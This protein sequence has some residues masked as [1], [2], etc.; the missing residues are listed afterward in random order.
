M[1]RT[2]RPVTAKVVV[3]CTGCGVELTKLAS[4]LKRNKTGRFFC[5]TDCRDRIGSKPR[6]GEE[7]PCAYCGNLYYVP[8][9]QATTSRYCS[10]QCQSEGKKRREIRTCNTCGIDFEFVLAMSKWNAGRFCSR[11]C[12]VQRP[13]TRLPKRSSD[14]YMVLWRDGK[15]VKEH[16]VVMEEH[17]GRPLLPGENV[18]HVNG[19]KTDNRLENLELWSTSQPC[20][21][22]VADKVAWAKELLALYQ[23]E[24]LR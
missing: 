1:P 7:R 3:N 19:V 20:G 5:S 13:E 6:T 18:H 15:Y 10:K 12:Y 16:R 11:T 8:S 22:R 9:L 24:V 21:Q 14:G 4:D 23:P 17:L 2:G